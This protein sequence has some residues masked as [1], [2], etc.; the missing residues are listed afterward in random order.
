MKF[1]RELKITSIQIID[2]S[3]VI[4]ILMGFHLLMVRFILD[5]GTATR[6]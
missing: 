1:S 5:I 2:L 3:F 6:T 4:I